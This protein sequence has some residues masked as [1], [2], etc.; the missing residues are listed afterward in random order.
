VTVLV[1]DAEEMRAAMATTER[2]IWGPKM[3]L[4]VKAVRLLSRHTGATI[5]ELAEE[6]EVNKRTVYRI[7]G[8][9]EDLIGAELVEV[10]G[11][12]QQE[13]RFKFPPGFTLNL[14]LTTISGLTVPELMALYALR[15]TA[16]LFKGSVISEDI[17]SAFEKISAALSPETK[18]MLERYATL[19][20]SVPKTPKDYS[21]HADTIE[22]LC[23]A[24]L[25]RKTCHITYSTYSDEEITEKTYDINP[26]HF[27]ERDGG[28]YVFVVVTFYGNIRLL[29]VERIKRIE[30][31]EKLFDWPQNFDPEA[32]LNKAFG[33]YWDDSLTVS[34]KFPE[35]Q[36][37]YIRERKWAEQQQ[38]TE[39]PDGS[40]ILTMET[41]GRY[42]VKRWV[43]S[44]SCDAELLEPVELRNEIQQEV[45]EMAQMYE[46]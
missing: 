20:I 21:D 28:L 9:L 39:Q 24:I 34:I 40:I 22:E 33:L 1:T 29:A 19:F 30:M 16:G 41:S 4:L 45:R 38:I 36:A 42:D 26:L 10:Q 23:Y 14:P 46:K 32:L 17:E 2:N 15:M 5:N 37:R 27:F 11:F 31:T 3:V 8:T 13:K 7:K 43:M 44:F 12:M 35:S 6:L 25:E 18:K